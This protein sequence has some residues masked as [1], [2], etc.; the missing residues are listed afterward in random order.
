[1]INGCTDMTTPRFDE[2]LRLYAAFARRSGAPPEMIEGAVR[3][4]RETL[5]SVPRDREEALLEQV[6]FE[7]LRLFYCGLWIHG[8][9]ARAAR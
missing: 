5:Y 1:M 2:D 8:W 3:M 7:D 9:V 6:G 4:Q